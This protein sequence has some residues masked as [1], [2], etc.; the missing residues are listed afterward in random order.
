MKTLL[1]KIGG[2]IRE[3]QYE[4]VCGIITLGLLAM[5]LFC[6]PNALGRLVE[7]LRDIGVS[8]AYV[9]CDWF[10]IEPNFTVTVNKYPNYSFLNVKAWLYSLFKKEYTP[11]NPTAPFP[12]DWEAFKVKWGQYWEDFVDV[13]NMKLYLYYL[14][15]YITLIAP[16]IMFAF[17]LWLGVKS[18]FDKYYFKEPKEPET[19]EEQRDETR[20]IMESKPLQ[21]WHT[22]YFT[23]LARIGTWFVGLFDFVKAREELYQFWLLLVLLYFNVLTMF[24]EFCAYYL[25]FS[26]AFDFVNLYRQLYKL[27]L[28]LS[29]VL[30]VFGLFSWTT[31]IIL[32]L[33]RKSKDLEIERMRNGEIVE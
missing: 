24:F 33:K 29:A 12:I 5:G 13:D 17:P 30:S 18:L 15:Y 1:R 4:Y 20:P 32:V 14:G 26:V 3:K 23:V 6:F 28:D 21:K 27:C 7:S 2:N 25:Y 19:E 8:I 16:L 11:I 10:E 9:F 31:I 22:F